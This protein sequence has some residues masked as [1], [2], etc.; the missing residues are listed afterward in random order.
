MGITFEPYIVSIE[1]VVDV[2]LK[3]RIPKIGK[4]DFT[5]ADHFKKTIDTMAKRGPYV[6][7]AYLYQVAFQIMCASVGTL[8]PFE[9]LTDR[10]AVPYD[11]LD[12]IF[13]K[14]GMP[15]GIPYSGFAPLYYIMQGEIAEQQKYWTPKRIEAIGKKNCDENFLPAI[16]EL[17]E[18][19][20]K[21]KKDVYCFIT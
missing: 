21:E 18:M 10:R 19:A 4:D 7:D 16:L 12:K 1:E 11:I 6:E 13:K 3:K 17:F 20:Q 2:I 8:A 15:F 9:E 5:S 14:G